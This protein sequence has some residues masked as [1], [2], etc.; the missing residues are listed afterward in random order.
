MSS[1]YSLCFLLHTYYAKKY[2]K[3]LEKSHNQ[4]NIGN[5]RV[6]MIDLSLMLSFLTPNPLSSLT[7]FLAL[8]CPNS[9]VDG[10]VHLYCLQAHINVLLSECQFCHLKCVCTLHSGSAYVKVKLCSCH[11]LSNELSSMPD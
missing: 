3:K 10:S 11:I 6:K 7:R 5:Y 1:M 2:K 8:T 9:L 4:C